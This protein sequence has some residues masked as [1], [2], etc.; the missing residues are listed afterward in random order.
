MSFSFSLHAPKALPTL[1]TTPHGTASLFIDSNSKHK[2]SHYNTKPPQSLHHVLCNQ[3]QSDHVYLKKPSLALH[4]GA[5]LALVEQ[6]ALA[7]TGENYQ[8]ELT[9]VLI[10]LGIVLF[11]YFIV[12]P[13]I[14][15]NWM[16][17]RWYRRKFLEMYF[18]FMFAF[19]F[20]PGIILWAPFLN[21]RKFPRDPS[22]KYPWSVPEDLSKV[23]NAYS[24]Y[25]YAEP[26]DYDWP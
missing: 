18:Q 23:R 7:V 2:A 20:F 6:P 3:K 12:A 13:P 24:K 16:R 1:P 9:S 21:F 19:I 14:I 25:P 26:E 15:M 5:L 17:I 10:Q 8:P 4:I 11:L 22:L